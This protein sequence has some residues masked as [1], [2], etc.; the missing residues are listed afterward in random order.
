MPDVS[1]AILALAAAVILAT[2]SC[3]T[4]LTDASRQRVTGMGIVLL[5]VAVV[6][7][8]IAFIEKLS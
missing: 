4:G 5:V 2:E 7:W 1:A 3:A 8:L 6:C